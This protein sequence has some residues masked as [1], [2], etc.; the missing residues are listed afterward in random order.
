MNT[1]SKPAKPSLQ[2]FENLTIQ[3]DLH[4]NPF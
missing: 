3:E 2:I 1:D 4:R